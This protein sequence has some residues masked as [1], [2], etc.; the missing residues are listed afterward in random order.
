MLTHAAM[1]EEFAVRTAAP[2]SSENNA[3]HPV[4]GPMTTQHGKG[5][6]EGMKKGQ[7]MKWLDGATCRTDHAK[8]R[9]RVTPSGGHKLCLMKNSYL[10]HLECKATTAK[11]AC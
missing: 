1:P 11:R 4:P 6:I 3:F 8:R 2:G 10:Q 9:M 5:R 7:L